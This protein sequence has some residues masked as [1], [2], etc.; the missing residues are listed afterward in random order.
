MRDTTKEKKFHLVM[1]IV[2]GLG[3]LGWIGA[4]VKHGDPF[5]IMAC[6]CSAINFALNLRSYF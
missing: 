2:W 4:F 3:A 1:T 6:V 5:Q